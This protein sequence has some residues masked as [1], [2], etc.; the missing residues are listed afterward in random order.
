MAERREAERR[1]VEDEE[2]EAEAKA[3]AKEAR[4]AVKAA[5]R[6][7]RRTAME[8]DLTTAAGA[9]E[10]SAGGGA[11]AEA[12]ARAAAAGGIGQMTVMLSQRARDGRWAEM[13]Q[14]RT[15]LQ[16]HPST[17]GDAAPPCC[18]RTAR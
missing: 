15:E 4:K 2:A 16:V 1:A 11:D 5:E 7:A 10:E 18:L 6:E 3:A 17:V 8:A 12:M 9:G 13:Q 14:R